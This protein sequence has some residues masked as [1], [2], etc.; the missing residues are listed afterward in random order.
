MILIVFLQDII[1]SRIVQCVD[2][3]RVEPQLTDSVQPTA[4]LLPGRISLSRPSCLI[5]ESPVVVPG[6]SLTPSS[7][8]HAAKK[9]TNEIPITHRISLLIITPDESDAQVGVFKDSNRSR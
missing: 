5:S 8:P 6:L 4:I 7:E 9:M 1:E 2:P 3:N